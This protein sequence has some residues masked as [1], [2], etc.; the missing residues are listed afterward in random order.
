MLGAFW[1]SL[2]LLADVLPEVDSLRA[3]LILLM[4]VAGV[5]LFALMLGVY[6]VK[7]LFSFSKD[8]KDTR[9][10]VFEAECPCSL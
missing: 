9:V 5:C 2:H 8:T 6:L 4:V 10:E 1:A 7:P 3:I